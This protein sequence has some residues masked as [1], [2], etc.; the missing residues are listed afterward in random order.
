MNEARRWALLFDLDGTLADT[1]DFLL[2]SVRHAFEGHTGRIPTESEWK[3]GIGTPLAIQLRPYARS[4]E[5]LEQLRARYRAFQKLHHDR[6]TRA[7]DGALDVVTSLKQLGHATAV[8]TSKGKE[9]AKR[10]LEV[11]R[12]DRV[13]DE[14]ITV[15]DV[16]RAKPDPEPVLLALERLR[17]PA[18]RALFL[19]DSPHDVAAGKAAGVLTIAATWGVTTE[20]MF[21][22]A[23]PDYA[24]ARITELPGLVEQ[25]TRS[26]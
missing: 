24:L 6:L 19:G 15:E 13:V 14:L 17:L 2:A 10:S 3:A 26:R 12:L 11:T 1:I 21:R 25:L 23:S 7:F 8:V 9:L 5:E 4:D 22:E 18:E 20:E 16:T